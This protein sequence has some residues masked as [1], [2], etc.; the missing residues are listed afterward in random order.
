MEVGGVEG[1]RPDALIGVA[2][3][4]EL[5]AQPLVESNRLG[6]SAGTQKERERAQ[7]RRANGSDSAACKGGGVSPPRRSRSS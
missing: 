1:G 2:H 6:R 5:L 7:A 3:L 4:D